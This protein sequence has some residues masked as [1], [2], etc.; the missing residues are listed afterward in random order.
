MYRRSIEINFIYFLSQFFD[1]S[2]IRVSVEYR[3]S[4]YRIRIRYRY[5][6][7]VKYRCNVAI[8]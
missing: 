2:S 7:L 1:T 3:V 6:T 4:E 8:S 5:D